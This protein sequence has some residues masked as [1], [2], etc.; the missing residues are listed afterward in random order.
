MGRK[1]GDVSGGPETTENVIEGG[2]GR[3]VM[4]GS[5]TTENV[6]GGGDGVTSREELK[7]QRM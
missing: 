7:Q 2:G 3:E 5:K 4:G 6:I 1:W